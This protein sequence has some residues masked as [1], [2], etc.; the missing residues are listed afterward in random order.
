MAGGLQPAS[1]YKSGQTAASTGWTVHV[2]SE[3]HADA[4]EGGLG[5]GGGGLCMAL[6]GGRQ[7]DRASNTAARKVTAC[8]S[9]HVHSYLNVS[10]HSPAAWEAAAREGA[11]AASQRDRAGIGSGAEQHCQWGQGQQQPSPCYATPI[12]SPSN[13]SSHCSGIP[14]LLCYFVL[15]GGLGGG[16]LGGGGLH[17]GTAEGVWLAWLHDRWQA[18]SGGRLHAQCCSAALIPCHAGTHEGGLGGGGDGGGGLCRQQVEPMGS[19]VWS[20]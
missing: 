8:W 5:G 1:S 4:H 2:L 10:Q 17:R 6:R 19:W 7:G 9:E 15:T 18:G 3:P 12:T 14:F 20:D 16:G 11:G 13:T